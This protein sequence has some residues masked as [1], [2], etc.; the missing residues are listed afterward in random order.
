MNEKI[1]IS[2]VT[3]MYNEEGNVRAFYDKAT[4]VLKRI[5]KK[6]EIIFADDGSKDN[7][8]KL[9]RELH[10]KDKRVKVVR[11]RKNFGKAAALSAGFGQ[12]KGDII[13]TLDGDLQDEPNE[14]PKFLDKI[15]QGYDLVTGWKMNKHKGNLKRLSS[16]IF[17]R[18]SSRLT[19][20]KIHDFNCPFKAYKNEVVK[21]IN[22]YGEMHRYIP[23]L[24]HWKGYRIAEIP[25]LNYPRKSGKSKYNTKRLLKGFL[26][27][28]TVKYL[29]SY[30]S[31]P[32]HLFGTIGLVF[33]TL[34]VITGLYLITQWLLGIGIGKR[35]LL[36]LS[37]LMTMIGIQLI[38]TGLIGE[39]ITNNT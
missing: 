3:P 24:A 9:L 25:V 32:L 28:V 19:G 1:E 2:V 4:D 33:T 39:M 27:L 5:N 22:L 36:M 10:D 37:I 29:S 13:I 34:G 16:L 20:V 23:A 30:Y 11:L 15:S 6:Y 7:T 17:N 21:N 26:D 14:I 12:A 38:S 35:P 31:K 18:L 8:F